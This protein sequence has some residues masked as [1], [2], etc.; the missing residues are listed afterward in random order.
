MAIYNFHGKKHYLPSRESTSPSQCSEC[1]WRLR[2][3]C[4]IDALLIRDTGTNYHRWKHQLIKQVELND[5][6]NTG[7]Y[8]TT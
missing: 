3:E 7:F 6:N 2:Y 4:C 1:N 5:T 8:H